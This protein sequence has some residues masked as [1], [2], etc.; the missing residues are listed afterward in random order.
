MVGSTDGRADTRGSR[1]TAIVYERW[2]NDPR[3]PARRKSDRS[4]C[5]TRRVCETIW[6]RRCV[7]LIFGALMFAACGGGHASGVGAHNK[8]DYGGQYLALIAPVGH[9]IG[10]LRRVPSNQNVPAAVISSFETAFNNFNSAILRDRWPANAQADIKDLVRADGPLL[11]DVAQIN[12]QTSATTAAFANQL[13]RDVNA[14][15]VAVNIVRADL[16][17][18]PP[19]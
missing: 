10:A 19:S 13:S 1:E 11:A 9:A 18:P 14:W 15:S 16:G 5:E 12:N 17:L 8:I 6:W 2:S 3:R 7:L 4:G